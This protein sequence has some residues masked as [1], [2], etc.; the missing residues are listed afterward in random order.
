[1]SGFGEVELAARC[2]PGRHY[3]G[4]PVV[5]FIPQQTELHFIG[6]RVFGMGLQPGFLEIL[7]C[8]IFF[9]EGFSERIAE[10]LY[11]TPGIKEGQEIAAD[12][13]AGFGKVAVISLALC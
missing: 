13:M 3:S 7:D 4:L 5:K 8:D 2:K 10:N 12:G 6:F 11:P 1:M 9:N